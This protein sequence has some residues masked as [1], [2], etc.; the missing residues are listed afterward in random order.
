MYSDAVHPFAVQYCVCDIGAVL[1]VMEGHTS[2][3]LENISMR[4]CELL[5]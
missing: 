5:K 2:E 3:I 1:T 4:P